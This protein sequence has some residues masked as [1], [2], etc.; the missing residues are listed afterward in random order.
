MPT[1]IEYHS[2]QYEKKPYHFPFLQPTSS[3]DKYY[4]TVQLSSGTYQRRVVLPQP[5]PFWNSG[6]PLFYVPVKEV[7]EILKSQMYSALIFRTEY[8]SLAR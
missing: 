5:Y 6:G 7:I 3:I 1:S 4:R 2:Q 8:S